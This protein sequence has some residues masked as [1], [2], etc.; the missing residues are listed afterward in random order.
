MWV[1]PGYVLGLV[2][3][4]K[5]RWEA[6][7]KQFADLSAKNPDRARFRFMYGLAL[8]RQ[9]K[10]DDAYE[11]V[12][13]ALLA[14]P[15]R[16]SWVL[17]FRRIERSMES[18]SLPAL[19]LTQEELEKLIE[20][21]PGSSF[22]HSEL[23]KIHH[24]ETKWW[25]EVE[26]LKKA[27]KCFGQDADLHFRLGEALDHMKQR[28]EAAGCYANA[29]E[30][31]PGI[32][33]WHYH[34]GY[35]L[36]TEG[37]DGPPDPVASRDHYAKA[38]ELH[39]NEDARKFG[40]GLYHQRFERWSLAVSAYEET[41]RSS[42]SPALSAKLGLCQLRL[43]EWRKAVESLQ[44]A[45]KA[46]SPMA[47]WAYQLG[48]AHER[49]GEFREA[50]EAY[51][52][53]VRIS[54]TKVPFWHYRHGYALEKAGEPSLSCEA[55][56][57]ALDSSDLVEAPDGARFAIPCGSL[58]DTARAMLEP[59]AMA[60][61]EDA[62]NETLWW[63]LGKC[64]EVLGE[65]KAAA[66]A[67]GNAVARNSSHMPLW[68]HRAGFCHS[69]AGEHQEACVFF[70]NSRVF[71]RPHG[72][73]DTVLRADPVFRKSAVYTEY[74]ET[75][76]IQPRM[77]M[78]ESFHARLMTCNPF[79]IFVDLLSRPGFEGWT[80][81][82]VINDRSDV[83]PAFRRLRNVIL[84]SRNSDSYQRYLATA[85]VLVNNVTFYSYFI[86]RPEQI[87]LNTWHGTPWKMLGKDV[88][89]ELLTYGNMS[90]NFI[91]ATHILS[92]NDHST[93]VFL[94]GFDIDT[95]SHG[96]IVR[97]GYPRVDLTL[98]AEPERRLALKRRL[99]ADDG[100]KIV[101]YAPTWRGTHA[102]PEQETET[103]CAEMS[104]LSGLDCHL[105]FRGHTLSGSFD[106][107]ITVPDDITTNE[108]LSIVDVLVTDYSSVLFDFL[109]TRRPVILFIKDYEQ[110]LRD[111]GLY[112]GIE[113][114]PASAASGLDELLGRVRDAIG[115]RLREDPELREQA[116]RRYCPEE[117]GR[118]CERV[119]GMILEG[120][121]TS[122]EA[123][124]HGRRRILMFGGRF[125]PNG[126]TASL[127]HLLESLD[128]SKVEVT[129]L[130]E[131]ENITGSERNSECFAKVPKHVRVIP[132]VGRMNMTIEERHIH[133][134]FK[135][136]ARLPENPE[137]LAIFRGMFEREY[138]RLLGDSRFDAA[139]DF[140]GYNLYWASLIAFMP[141]QAAKHRAIYQHNDKLGE[142]RE[143]FP[144]LE[145]I[146]RLYP[147]FD[148]LVSV[149]EKTMELNASSLSERYGVPRGSFGFA[150]NM[151]D[152]SV[153]LAMA[154]EP[155]EKEEDERW[156][157]G[158][159]PVF[160][161]MGR[162]SVEK[163]HEKLIRAF[164]GF[165]K[166]APEARLLIIG[167]GPLQA[168]L[169]D[170]VKRLKLGGKVRLPGFRK[171]PFPYLKR[172]DCFVLSSNHEG[173]PMVLLEAL[174]LGKP[175]VATDIAGNRGVLEG[176]ADL[177][178]E[179]S[180]EGLIKGMSAFA[181]GAVA[182]GSLDIEA[183]RR[184]SLLAFYQKSCGF[185]DW[186][187][188]A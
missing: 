128:E 77:V 49:L 144:A 33:L 65:W 143:R 34:L 159:G 170:L 118:A 79:A 31:R 93:G 163:D 168:H 22:L 56:L 87:Y 167:D 101:L 32:A 23:A 52:R 169:R 45:M 28:R 181:D 125:L 177:L 173:Q 149:S 148:R 58:E 1:P 183:Y 113:E 186:P 13:M 132:R 174:I 158:P 162:L 9:K 107:N 92:S 115:G 124:D 18:R 112:F 94:R 71:Q 138:D 78:Y 46:K 20:E 48:M 64:R 110:Y 103:L 105:L 119:A 108:L 7:E 29:L 63:E 68:Y 166:S 165:R 161:T 6:A 151:L 147:F 130:V 141:G 2:H 98:N 180:V 135:R 62:T 24:I 73:P 59:L 8:A 40:I 25:Q 69:R 111:R 88:R 154:D 187:A 137:A 50:A 43:Y 91:H 157:S 175:I 57:A 140:E 37:H 184:N 150:E 38:V 10:W 96:R 3:L 35:A 5:E 76:E 14:E 97:S 82:W 95:L 44:S 66:E 188:G 134:T 102:E 155:L 81:V 67:Y 129:L 121:R 11:E 131:P 99:G 106:E 42:P 146:F 182:A 136:E 39:G 84:V 30:L 12:R 72:V 176:R 74:V 109:P 120:P 85:G 116:L 36:A 145:L 100:R 55:H 164:A 19:P 156:F 90:H 126:I 86:R 16:N 26:C 53:A 178:V 123:S 185:G 70:R 127:I 83:P 41:S 15:M 4:K 142:C 75:L 139:I 160:I 114:I 117:D 60:L 80:H 17:H 171:N 51:G 54:E 61:E 152:G 179:N 89:G 47:Q 133:E 172:A 21:Y 122:Q 153:V 104:A 27:V